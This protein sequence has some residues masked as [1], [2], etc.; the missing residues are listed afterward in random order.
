[1]CLTNKTTNILSVKPEIIEKICYKDIIDLNNLR[2]GLKRTKINVSPGIDGE[3]KINITES[4]LQKLYLEL[5]LQTYQPKPSKKFGIAQ[6]GDG[7]RYLGV[8]S[9]IDK[10]VQA[11]LLNHL[12]PVLEKVFKSC[13]FGFRPN[14]NCHN[15]LREIK[16][17]WKAISWIIKVDIKKKFDRLNHDHILKNLSNYCDQ[18][19]VEL[20]RKLI[21]VGYV[22]IHNLTDRGEYNEVGVPQGSLLSPILLNLYLHDLDEYIMENLMPKYNKE[23]FK[24]KSRDDSTQSFDSELNTQLVNTYPDLKQTLVRTKQNSFKS[25]KTFNYCRLYYNRYADDFILGFIGPKAEADIILAQIT[26]KLTEIKLEINTEKSKI[27]H[28]SESGIE[29][30]RMF[31][32]YFVHSKT[33]TVLESKTSKNNT[34]SKIVNKDVS[35]KIPTAH[36]TVPVAILLKKLVDKG[37]A[38]QRED[39]TIRGTAYI[40]V[41]TWEEKQIVQKY[42]SIIQS[43]LNYYSCINHKS[44]LWKI[45]AILRKSCALTLAHKLKLGS[46]AKIYAK[47]GPHLKIKGVGESTELFYPTSLKS[48]VDFK[49][50][51][52][53]IKYPAVMELEI[54]AVSGPAQYNP[55]PLHTCK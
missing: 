6:L 54:D 16:Y 18:S 48:K 34:I 5:S 10:I 3:T 7:M 33:I 11:A 46:A 14:L 41:S 17:Q 49:I 30:L 28:S 19:T 42:S 55:K 38:K 26:A 15:A 25:E 51:S 13:S 27:Y 50:R 24:V 12:E 36:F 39:G 23:E 31:I 45:L 2:A 40:K 8:A 37:L 1:M 44:D 35:P 32:R 47:F 52:K 9:Q 21:K 53:S 22:D 4:R 43:L 20:V 29:Y